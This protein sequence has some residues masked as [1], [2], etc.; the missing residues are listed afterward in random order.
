MALLAGTV[1]T[2]PKITDRAATDRVCALLKDPKRV[3]QGVVTSVNQA[4]LRLHRQRNLV[5]HSGST[6]SVALSAALRTTPS[7]VGA[8]I[9]R[10]VHAAAEEGVSPLVGGAGGRLVVD[11]LS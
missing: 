8:G 7:L 6:N 4:L 10:V 11:L 9:D 3:L 2:T 1:L 5:M